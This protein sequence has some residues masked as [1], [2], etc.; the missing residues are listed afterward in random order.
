MSDAWEARRQAEALRAAAL[1]A[2]GDIDAM[3]AERA[4]RGG[5]G[6]E[7]PRPPTPA[8][9][10][11]QA[12]ERPVMARDWAAERMWVSSVA[13]S[14]IDAKLA[15]LP[16]ALGE[17][18]AGERKRHRGEIEAPV[19]LVSTLERRVAELETRA[20][21]KLVRPRLVE[22]GRMPPDPDLT[23]ADVELINAATAV[24][25]GMIA[26][27]ED[28]EELVVQFGRLL[29]AVTKWRRAFADQPAVE[30]QR[31]IARL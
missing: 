2:L 17:V 23:E 31:A 16:E 25:V 8:P 9:V 24:V 13:T 18:I 27:G 12:P 4:E 6:W 19:E 10:H 26:A 28:R 20:V 1:D 29:S 3:L 5:S 21:L 30:L 14:V 22:G 15:G 11:Q 7:A